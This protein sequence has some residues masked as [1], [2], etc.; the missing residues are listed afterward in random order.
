[1]KNQTFKMLAVLSSAWIVLYLTGCKA[2]PP[3]RIEKK[4]AHESKEL[5]VG[6]KD[7][8]NPVPDTPSSAKLGAEDFQRHCQFCH[9]V[10]GHATGVPF[11]QNMS[12]PVPDLA[13]KDIQS[14][15]DGQLKWI[16]ENGIRLSGMPR[17]KG[18][19]QDEE[20]WRMVRYMRHLPS[21]K[22]HSQN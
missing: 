3:S 4:L 20:M 7:W 11:A 2:K 19:L 12:P 16:I 9:G 13:A 17:W 10:D 8:N 1:M 21:T 22:R 14:Y 5:V 15:T 18:L 6:G